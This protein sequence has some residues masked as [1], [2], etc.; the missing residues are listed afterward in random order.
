MRRRWVAGVIAG[1]LAAGLLAVWGAWTAHL[2]RQVRALA[3]EL[4]VERQRNF[5]EMISHVEAMR[6]LMGKSLAAGSTRQ[7]ALYMGEVYRRA[8]LAAAN[9]MALPLPEELGAATGKFLNQIGDF[10]YSVVRNEAAG[11]AMDESQ[12]A[13]LAR[14]YQTASDLTATLREAGKSAVNEGFRFARAGAGLSDLFTAWRQRGA[15]RDPLQGQAAKHLLPP[16][17]DQMGAQMDQMPVLV[18]DG[19]FSDHLEERTPA[20][21]GPAITPEEAKAKALAYLPEG[22]TADVLEVGERNG[23]LPVYA[24]RLAPGGGRPA[25][26]VDLSREGGHLV[27]YI[28]A[29]P[30]GEP[31]LT[32][33]EAREAGLAYLAAHGWTEMEPTYGEVA[34][35]FATVQYV[36]A[37]GGV[38]IYPDQVKVRIALDSGEV[39]GV[40][41]RSYVMSHR[42]RGGLTPAVT[43][44]QARAAVN[45]ELQVEEARLALIPTEAGDGE[46][47]CWEFRGT[48]GG[49]TYLVYV[50]A[51]TGLEERILQMLITE[52]GTLAL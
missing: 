27:S 24:V 11:R 31:R 38:R 52:N 3:S 34:G 23:R 33:E 29:R 32:L 36:Y 49:D 26:A 48:L 16:G 21:G 46:V 10:A 22:I 37:P 7:N 28:N 30:A 42:E 4:E 17:L 45:P 43:R 15:G 13:E 40:D 20:M 18:Y 44:E 35:G 47:L 5:A 51:H 19:P 14:L 41:A 8:S 6:G 2:Q 25:A 12:R 9:F 1:L 50:N 39:V